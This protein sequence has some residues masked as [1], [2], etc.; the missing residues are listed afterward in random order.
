MIVTFFCL[1]EGKIPRVGVH[2]RV[3][4]LAVIVPIKFTRIRRTV[5]LLALILAPGIPL[6]KQ[7]ICRPAEYKFEYPTNTGMAYS[8]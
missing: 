7:N 4:Y 8:L 3:R 6:T 5:L 1:L 2:A